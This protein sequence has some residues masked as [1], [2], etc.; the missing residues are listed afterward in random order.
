MA[1][2]QGPAGLIFCPPWPPHTL[3]LCIAV[4]SSI[5]LSDQL[6]RHSDTEPPVPRNTVFIRSAGRPSRFSSCVRS[7]MEISADRRNLGVFGGY[8]LV[9]SPRPSRGRLAPL[10]VAVLRNR[11][12]FI[13]PADVQVIFRGGLNR[14][15]TGRPSCPWRPLQ[16]ISISRLFSWFDVV[17]ETVIYS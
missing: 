15:R 3:E 12:Q 2:E 17:R 11:Q 5:G 13:V 16:H 1:K 8:F 7:R 4:P 6:R 10:P 14:G 9:V